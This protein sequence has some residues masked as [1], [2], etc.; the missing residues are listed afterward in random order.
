M[1]SIL[2]EGFTALLVVN[3]VIQ[4]T[5]CRLYVIVHL[6]TLTIGFNCYTPWS[7]TAECYII[8]GGPC[9]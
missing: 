2:Y 3:G 9:Q 5:L 7:M 6:H 1:I 4:Y 8:Q